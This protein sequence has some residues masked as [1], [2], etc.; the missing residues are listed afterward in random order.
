MIR[1]TNRKAYCQQG[2]E[3]EGLM[4]VL[5]NNPLA[6]PTKDIR[7]PEGFTVVELIDYL[8]ERNFVDRD[9]F[10]SLCKTKLKI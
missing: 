10:E 9:R 3:H 7:I 8:T 2:I 6:E 1:N 4:L 5:T